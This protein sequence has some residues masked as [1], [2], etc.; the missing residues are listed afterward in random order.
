MAVPVFLSRKPQRGSP[1]Q[2]EGGPPKAAL[3]T[4]THCGALAIP[5]ALGL[6]CRVLSRE[7]ITPT[8]PHRSLQ[9]FIPDSVAETPAWYLLD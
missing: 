5:Q 8:S 9:P 3:L 4:A 6:C 1:C 2:A 7:V